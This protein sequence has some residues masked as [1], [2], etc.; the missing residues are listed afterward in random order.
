[1]VTVG[2]GGKG[3][4]EMVQLCDLVLAVPSSIAA[5]SA[6]SH[7]RG[8]RDLRRGGSYIVCKNFW[9]IDMSGALDQVQGRHC[10][11]GAVVCRGTKK[12][13]RPLIL[14]FPSVSMH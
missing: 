11:L 2:F 9:Q 12:N 13:C 4:G 14:L 6:N 7:H 1:M 8:T 3:G 10:A 5:Y